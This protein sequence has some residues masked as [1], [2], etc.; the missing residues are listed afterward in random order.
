MPLGISKRDGNETVGNSGLAIKRD[1]QVNIYIKKIPIY[2][3]GIAW[4]KMRYQKIDLHGI[5]YSK[6]EP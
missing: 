4:K 5:Q 3:G 6:T 2:I 1:F